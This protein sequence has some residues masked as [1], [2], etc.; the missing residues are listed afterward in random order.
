MDSEDAPALVR[1]I[2]WLFWQNISQSLDF[3]Y[4]GA[5]GS[6]PWYVRWGGMNLSDGS[7]S[8]NVEIGSIQVVFSDEFVEACRS[9][10]WNVQATVHVF[11][12][13]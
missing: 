5:A 10:G 7:A 6:A 13:R 11:T 12:A 2:H 4:L 1:D 9:Q 8:L 3:E